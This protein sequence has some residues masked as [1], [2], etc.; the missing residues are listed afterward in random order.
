MCGVLYCHNVKS[1][2]EFLFCYLSALHPTPV[3]PRFWKKSCHYL[4]HI[5]LFDVWGWYALQLQKTHANRKSTSKSRKYFHHFDSRWCKCSQHKQI[6]KHTANA[7]N[8]TK[9][10]LFAAR[11]FFVCVV[12][13]CSVCVVKF[14]KLFLNLQ[15]IELS[16][17]PYSYAHYGCSYLIKNTLKQQLCE[18]LLQFK[19]SIAKHWK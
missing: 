18:I 5:H 1:T 13:I 17:P 4:S 7:H 12:S 9:Y 15:R 8:T 6:K 3:K 19:W 2:F 10:I 14:R 16:R 11:F